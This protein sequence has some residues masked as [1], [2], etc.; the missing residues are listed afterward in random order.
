MKRG[1]PRPAGNAEDEVSRLIKTLDETEKRLEK[2]TGGEVDTIL[3]AD[4]K[5]FVLP[6]ARDELQLSNAARQS[7]ILN[8]LPAR[9]AL[10][11]A[12][13]VIISV[14]KA[15]RQF[16]SENSYP[17]P[18]FGIGRN[19]LES[20]DATTGAHSADA[21]T[22]AKGIRS[23]LAGAAKSFSFEYSH[24][25]PGKD[26]WFLLTATP[27]SGSKLGGAVI[28]HVNITEQK[29]S[30]QAL[31]ESEARFRGTFEQAAVGIAHVSIEGSFIRLNDKFCEIF[32]RSR[33][34]LMG[35]TFADLAL[36]EERQ[37]SEEER[38]AVLSGG[39]ASSTSERRYRRGSGE[40]IWGNLVST[41][42]HN[43]E[44]NVNYV[45]S[46]FQNITERKRAEAAYKELSERTERR[47]RLL[48][49][50]LSSLH[51]FAYIFDRQGRFIFANRP[52]LDL[53][54]T[55]L[56]DI[57]GKTFLDLKYPEALA[58][59]LQR[60]IEQVFET[61]QR[62][63]DE[64]HYVT[65]AGKEGWYEYIFTPAIG[66]DGL[67]DFVV[68]STRDIT[69]RRNRNE[70]LR[71][72]EKRF[73]ALFDQMAMGVAQVDAHSGL[74]VQVNQRFCDIAGRERR[75]LEQLNA[76]KL[77][78]PDDLA[79]YEA[80]T[81]RIRTGAIREF[82]TEKRYLRKD[83]TEV[84]VQVT[85]SAMWA[86]GES[87]DYFTVIAQD[88]TGR[89]TLEEQFR[90][91]QKMDA[92]GTL[93]GGIAHDFNNILASIHG[94]TE[95]AQMVTTD[96]PDVQKYLAAVLQAARRA[97]GL[98]RQIL[99]FSRQQPLE[100]VP[101]QLLPVVIEALDLLRATIPST[102]A[103]DLSLASDAP[104]VLADSTQIHQILM[105]L[106]TNAWHAMKER[107]GR[108]RVSLERCEIDSQRAS[109]QQGLRPGTYAHVSVEDTGSGMD[110]S[111]M[112][113]IFEP[114][115]TTK[116][117]DEGT[118][119]GL[120]MVHGI[121][122][123]HDGV[124]TVQ[125]QPGKGTVF[126]LYFPEHLAR[127]IEMVKEDDRTPRGNGERILFVDD[128]E[129]LAAL[130][131]RA[132]TALGYE[133]EATTRTEAALAMISAEPARFDLVLTDFT[134]P[135]M[136]G[137]QF[138]AEVWRIN[139][140]L[141]AILLTGYSAQLTSERVEEMG[142][143]KL[144]LKPVSLYSLGATVHAVLSAGSADPVSRADAGA[145]KSSS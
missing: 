87:A 63:L 30:E 45:I 112:R 5:V 134:M 58:A 50:T 93:A 39:S 24:S 86:P 104:V 47:E 98:V 105:N 136:T 118:G 90:Q 23:V 83:N 35:T 75:E 16:S 119:L 67:V 68:G 55:T 57:V 122:E 64:T 126:H 84:W 143:S 48:T 20:L 54:E 115:F 110:E 137:P 127:A 36:P 142:F 43:A 131:K 42:Q 92:I 62:I 99:T 121:M 117:K 96:N 138:A 44:G 116:K 1:R 72:S 15:W 13:G 66:D 4:G 6:R 103:F 69:E 34:S 140:E 102:I 81:A 26:R 106:G 94:Y 37:E 132:L 130:G 70:E 41:L 25:S 51:D 145:A 80:M 76:A 120:A 108:L 53:W 124:V 95:L 82:T 27:L 123:S 133:V 7:A 3:G 60:Q 18:R 59:R 125:S 85:I 128:E 22:S 139:P 33:E 111:T 12:R 52:L 49:T 97:A 40:V 29:V 89:K 38:Q 77:T 19:Y 141:P 10:L 107:V 14:N 71:V 114:F 9:I 46:V 113:R 11:D 101:V 100:R 79:R 129:Q 32:G 21:R 56:E 144:L 88:I 73:R 65:P 17:A 61:K 109:L 31:R 2:L 78:H 8:A 135:D 28:T 91:A 74:H